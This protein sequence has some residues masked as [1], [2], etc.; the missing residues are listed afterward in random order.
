MN[1]LGKIDD[2]WI[3]QSNRLIESNYMI[4]VLE[5]KLVRLLASMITKDDEEFKEY[6][7]KALDLAIALN[8]TPKNIYRELDAITDKLMS[9]YISIKNIHNDKFRKYHIIKNVYFENGI[10]T[11]KID[12]EMKDFYI[13]LNW[14]TKYQLKN[15][16][17][18]KSSY[19]FRIYELA[20]QYEKIGYRKISIDDLRKKLNI[21]ENQY[22]QYAN[23]K[24]R[25]I[26][27]S[28]KEI[29][30]YTDLKISIDEIK[31]SR[32]VIGIKFTIE[33]SK[34]KLQT[35]EKLKTDEYSNELVEA[36]SIVQ[37]IITKSI[38]KNISIS[39]SEKIYKSALKHET[40]T[41]T[42]ELIKEVAEYSKT[43]NIKNNIIGW[44]VKT[45]SIYEKP[46][47][48]EKKDNFNNFTQRKY[49]FDELEMKLL[50]WDK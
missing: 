31:E 22:P 11:M 44:M 26:K 42:F 2:N 8:I 16:M 7:F 21:E 41:N 6:K 32:K 4:T 9:R 45:V 23:L 48:L 20:K 14:Y 39:S 28:I 24:Q 29:N 19:S 17:Q 15:I 40:F 37:D 10:L 12:D 3:Y 5:Q 33:S 47:K 18:F 49:N 36:I 35:N 46:I 30:E 43:Q 27:I 1:D 38:G 25:I 34:P 13:S 50:G